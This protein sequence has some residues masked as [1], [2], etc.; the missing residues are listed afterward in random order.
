[1]DQGRWTQKG[2]GVNKRLSIDSEIDAAARYALR[3]IRREKRK[4]AKAETPKPP[5]RCAQGCCEYREG[6][7]NVQGND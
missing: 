7:R 5:E 6:E 1:M 2:G 4:Q 3:V